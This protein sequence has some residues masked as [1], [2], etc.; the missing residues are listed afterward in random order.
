M[1]HCA[2]RLLLD[3]SFT[4]NGK[5]INFKKKLSKI[6]SLKT[7]I[8][9][10][11]AEQSLK[12]TNS[13]WGGQPW[14]I[15]SESTPFRVWK[16]PFPAQKSQKCTFSEWQGNHPKC[17]TTEIWDSSSLVLVY[18]MVHAM[19]WQKFG[20]NSKHWEVFIFKM[21]KGG[22]MS[23]RDNALKINSKWDLQMQ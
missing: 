5:G 7:F 6:P 1:L 15:G 2:I 11:K 18:A 16:Y 14:T 17:C 9:K 22:K 8:Q 23:L 13:H 19:N 21:D 20:V 10:E 4:L 12:S 3:G